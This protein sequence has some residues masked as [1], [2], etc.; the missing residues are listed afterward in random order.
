M[1]TILVPGQEFWD[2]KKNQFVY[3]KATELHM[4]HSLVAISKWESKWHKPFLNKEDKTSEEILDYIKCMCITPNVPDSVFA[5]LSQKN[6]DDINAYIEN[7]YTATT[8]NDQQD[9]KKNTEVITSELIYYWMIA[10]QIPMEFQ[11]WHLNRLMTL[12]RVCNLKN[13]PKKKMSQAD[14]IKRHQSINTARRA[15]AKKQQE[16]V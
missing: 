1:L 4:E 14:L 5:S 16:T 13:Q 11:K 7:P 8:V 10:L 3:T 2:E 9:G 15:A 12:I 6:I